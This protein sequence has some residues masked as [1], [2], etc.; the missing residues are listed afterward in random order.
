MSFPGTSFPSDIKAVSDNAIE[1]IADRFDDLPRPLLVA[2]GAGDMAVEQLAALRQALIE[3]LSEAPKGTEDIAALATDWQDR[4]QKTA[5][6]WQDK[7]Q[8]FALDLQK[9]VQQAIQEWQDRVQEWQGR[10]QQAA[11]ELPGQAAKTAS[12]LQER[13]QLAA[14]DL[15]G[16]AQKAAAELPEQAQKVAAEI[17]QTIQ[18][19]AAQVPTK[20]QELL[21]ELPGKLSEFTNDVTLESLRDTVEAYTQLVGSIYGS[22][23]DRGDKAWSKVRSSSLKPGTVVEATSEAAGT[24]RRASSDAAPAA[25]QAGSP[26]SLDRPHRSSTVGAEGRRHALDRD[27]EVRDCEV[28]DREV[29][30]RQGC[31]LEGRDL[32][33]S[34]PEGRVREG[35]RRKGERDPGHVGDR[36]REAGEGHREAGVVRR[37]DGEVDRE[38]GR[39]VDDH[40]RPAGGGEAVYRQLIDRLTADR[41]SAAVLRLGS[42]ECPARSGLS[43]VRGRVSERAA[44][45]PDPARPG[46]RHRRTA[47]GGGPSRGDT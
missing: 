4:A 24:V 45:R 26:D 35:C 41:R 38:G 40:A 47:R 46:C 36:R 6:D 5:Q 28:R 16:S 42:P 17:A 22:L 12:D 9:K 3:Q 23:A 13:A 21:A 27:C 31:C 11:K 43:A 14:T 33:G 10:A 39:Q 25:C 37:L 29:R 7:A 34:L 20:S 8:A 2:I 32:E 15:P 1:Q 30:D 18:G 44:T 19:F